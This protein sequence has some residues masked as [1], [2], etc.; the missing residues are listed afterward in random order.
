MASAEECL[1]A[2]IQ[3]DEAALMGSEPDQGRL[4]M[5]RRFNDPDLRHGFQLLGDDGE[6]PKSASSLKLNL[7][8]SDRIRNVAASKNA[9]VFAPIEPLPPTLSIM[10]RSSS[11]GPDELTSGNA[12]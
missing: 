6:V 2:V 4:V 7:N 10:I 5:R 12:G 9:V 1:R 11:T 3:N 8:V